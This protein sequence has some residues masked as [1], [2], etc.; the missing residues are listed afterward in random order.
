MNP[1]RFTRIKK[2]YSD[3]KHNAFTSIA[4]RN[5]LIFIAFRS[6]K[7]HLDKNGVITVIVLNDLHEA[8]KVAEFALPK[9]DLR[10]PKIIEFKGDFYISAQCEWHDGRN[11]SKIFR[12]ELN[13]IFEEIPLSGIPCGHLMWSFASNKDFILGSAFFPDK[14]H[15]RYKAV[16]YK[17]LN[18][19]EWIKIADFPV[20]GNETFLDIDKNGILTALVREEREYGAIPTLCT[21]PFP[22]T[23]FEFF[24]LP[25][26]MEGMIVK[27]IGRGWII[28]GRCGIYPDRHNTRVDVFWL[29]DGKEIEFVRTLPSGGDCAYA[30]W[31]DI[32]NGQVLMSYYSSHE[33]KMAIPHIDDSKFKDPAIAEHT[34][35]ADIYLAEISVRKQ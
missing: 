3:G 1:I 27:R 18:M 4:K 13:N 33:H 5:N 10:D 22:F 29:E 16:L 9:A 28:V 14:Q 31:L 30:S 7:N 34:T 12:W 2:I 26:R 6:A 21:T 19:K 17:S 35:P 8:E 24:K 32:G 15:P 23:D 11:E 25:M 20:P